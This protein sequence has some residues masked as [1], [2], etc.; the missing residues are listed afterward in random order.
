M[1]QHTFNVIRLTK[2]PKSGQVHVLPNCRRSGPR[3]RNGRQV[4]RPS[5]RAQYLLSCVCYTAAYWYAR[6]LLQGEGKGDK[7]PY[8]N[9]GNAPHWSALPD[10]E[11]S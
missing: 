10:E 1:E 6:G 2:G 9:P 11:R 3:M 8:V 4:A 7:G 5:F